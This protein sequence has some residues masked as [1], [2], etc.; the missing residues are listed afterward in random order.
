MLKTL[1]IFYS[2]LSI[3]AKNEVLKFYSLSDPSDGNLDISPIAILELE[4][5]EVE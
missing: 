1:E 4:I 5:D 2:D 3:E